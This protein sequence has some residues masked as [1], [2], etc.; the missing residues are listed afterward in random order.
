MDELTDIVRDAISAVVF[1]R[2]GAFSWFGYR[3]GLIEPWVK[4][5]ANP[6]QLA[7]YLR[8]H[9]QLELYANFYV[10][11]FAAP[12]LEI[13]ARDHVEAPTLARSL[14]SAN[15]GRGLR[16]PGWDVVSRRGS[17]AVV[18]KDGLTLRVGAERL[19]SRKRRNVPLRHLKEL[20]QISPGFYTALGDQAPL[21]L[22]PLLRV[23]W[24]IRS[25]GAVPFIRHVTRL[26]NRA[27]IPFRAKVLTDPRRFDRCDA[28]VL[29]IA[30]RDSE[31]TYP[32]LQ[33][34]YDR[35]EEHLKPLT[36]VFTKQIAQGVGVAEDPRGDESFG[37]HR[38]GIV[39]GA[40][41][42]AHQNRQ[43]RVD[44]RFDEVIAAFEQRG[45]SFL[46]PFLDPGSTDRYP[47]L[48]T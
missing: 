46:K 16:E 20:H 21:P 14:S 44:A 23:Y 1:D 3:A 2:G 33:T 39:A 40:L 41:L 29:Y 31:K 36:P 28:A 34:V 19:G 38:C 35:L 37:Q 25:E 7:G 27:S 11:G 18:R 13:D 24:N 30:R 17:T 8:F 22:E 45:I 5:S 48:R 4:R 32:H 43:T 9:L 47:R 10:V 6:Q 26:L 15:A 42:R 12:I